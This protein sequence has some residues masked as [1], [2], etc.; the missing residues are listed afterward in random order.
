MKRSGVAAA[1]IL[2]VAAAADV[3]TSGDES[4]AVPTSTVAAGAEAADDCH[5]VLGHAVVVSVAVTANRAA[6]TP[7][8]FVDRPPAAVLPAPEPLLR[9]PLA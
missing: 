2:D 9:P 3:S 7:A 1:T 5:C 8:A 6:L 4:S